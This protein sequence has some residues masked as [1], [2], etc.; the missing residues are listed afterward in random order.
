[1]L[2]ES[3][4]NDRQRKRGK[5][6][7]QSSRQPSSG[8][9]HHH[10]NGS[11]HHHQHSNNQ[12]RLYSAALS[13][14][15]AVRE[16]FPLSVPPEVTGIID[17]ISRAHAST[18]PSLNQLERFR[19]EQDDAEV[20]IEVDV[21]LWKIFS[22]R[23]T[24]CIVKIVDFAKQ[25]PGFAQCPIADKITLIK[26]ASMDVLVLRLCSRYDVTE[27]SMTFSDGL[28][29][30][31]AQMHNCG[32]GP[33]T[34]NVYDFAKRLL[35]LEIDETEIGLLSALCI[36]CPDHKD[37]ED[38]DHVEKMQDPLL[39]A[40][41]LYSRKKRPNKPIIFPQLIMKI[42]DLRKISMRGSMR[43]ASLNQEIPVGTMPPL[44]SE[45]LL[46]NHDDDEIVE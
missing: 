12:R 23:S 33:I 5:E 28:T 25:I 43:V 35:P 16:I 19:W 6:K 22:E 26:K 46:R 45:M 41:R 3:V 9:A 2:R 1:M 29:L 24:K 42:Y 18:S 39:R 14:S 40:L 17:V 38:A 27:D 31:R 20:K 21:N 7:T 13:N 4:R 32:F 44:I 10:S 8:S 15:S 34:A 36:V 37:L 30:N 11:H